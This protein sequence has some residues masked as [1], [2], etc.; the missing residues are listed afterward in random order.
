MGALLEPLEGHATEPR[1]GKARDR[2][3]LG[4]A[5]VQA[6]HCVRPLHYPMCAK[7]HPWSDY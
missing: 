7:R 4:P 1:V 5:A 3:G 6:L 2:E